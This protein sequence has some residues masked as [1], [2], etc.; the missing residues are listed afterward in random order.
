MIR[1][2]KYLNA[3]KWLHLVLTPGDMKV[4]KI[5]I[6]ASYGVHEDLWSHTGTM[7]IFGKNSAYS[8]SLKQKLNY[9]SSTEVEVVGV[10]D[11]ITQIVWNSNFMGAQ[12]Q[13]ISRNILYKDNMPAMLLEKNSVVSACKRSKHLNIRFF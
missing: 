10:D 9:I 8:A 2:C 13:E 7:T 11:V 1:L 4:M 5:F 3:T 12:G 6:D